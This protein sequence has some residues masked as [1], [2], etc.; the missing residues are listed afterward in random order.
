MPNLTGQPSYTRPAHGSNATDSS[1]TD[2]TVIIGQLQT[3]VENIANELLASR[4]A[5]A[6]LLARLS[7]SGASYTSPAI[8]VA[9]ADASSAVKAGANYVCDGTNDQVEI[10]AAIDLA[11]P[12]NSRNSLMP[13]GAAQVGK[14]QL[15]GGRF[16]CGGSI[17]MRSGVHL[18][19]MG[20]ATEVRPVSLSAATGAG[21]GVALI[22]LAAATDHA[23]MVRELWLNGNFA[24]GGACH[25]IHYDMTGATD[26]TQYPTTD[27]D[28]YHYIQD[29]LFNGFTTG[30]RHNIWLYAA[31]TANNRAAMITGIT[32]RVPSGDNIRL[33]GCSDST[34]GNCHVGGAGGSNYYVSGGNTRIGNCKSMYANTNGLYVSSGRCTIGNFESQDDSTGVYIDGSP[35]V[36]HGLTIDTSSVAGLVVSTSKAQIHGFSIYNRGGGRYATTTKGLYIDSNSYTDLHLTGAV[37]PSLITTPITGTVSAPNRNFMRVTDGTSLVS[38]G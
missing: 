16:N 35:I 30:T 12:L 33:E 1:A 13:V 8:V 15:S 2:A 20:F 6:S 21:S 36:A 34:I 25:G 14:V 38:V 10:N 24:G 22:K 31:T 23:T 19:G 26:T 32:G 18:A 4:G 11:S 29:C 9:S 37:E 7:A 5:Y 28:A 27:P 3:D 17:L